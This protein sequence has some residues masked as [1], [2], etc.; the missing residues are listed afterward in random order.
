MMRVFGNIKP[1]F[2]VKSKVMFYFDNKACEF[3]ENYFE[4]SKSGELG[5][6]F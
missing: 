2:L 6:I 5:L 1:L 4:I 3:R